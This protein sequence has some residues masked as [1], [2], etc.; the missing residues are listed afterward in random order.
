MEVLYA[1]PLA[2]ILTRNSIKLL[3]W[4][5]KMLYQK[6]TNSYYVHIKTYTLSLYI[7]PLQMSDVVLQIKWFTKRNIYC[8]RSGENTSVT[9][10]I[11]ICEP[12]AFVDIIVASVLLHEHDVSMQKRALFK[13]D[14]ISRKQFKRNRSHRVHTHAPTHTHSSNV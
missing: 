14:Q 3:W 10:R 9:N 1:D 4:K 11:N 2:G 12:N 7:A 8:F 6:F 13:F 5:C